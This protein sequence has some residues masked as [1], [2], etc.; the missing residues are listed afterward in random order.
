MCFSRVKKVKIVDY[1]QL[2]LIGNTGN[3]CLRYLKI[4][5]DTVWMYISVSEDYL[6]ILLKNEDTSPV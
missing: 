6:R 2:Q 5:E 3:Q 4:G 1:W